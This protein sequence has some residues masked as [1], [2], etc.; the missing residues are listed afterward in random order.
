MSLDLPPPASTPNSQR[1]AG[2]LRWAMTSDPSPHLPVTILGLT[3]TPLHHPQPVLLLMSFGTMS[4]FPTAPISHLI[5]AR[6]DIEPPPPPVRLHPL[7]ILGLGPYKTESSH[8]SLYEQSRNPSPAPQLPISTLQG[9]ATGRMSRSSIHPH[10]SLHCPPRATTWERLANRLWEQ[11]QA[12]NQSYSRP[13]SHDMDI[14]QVRQ[15]AW[16]LSMSPIL[17]MPFPDT[18]P[19]NRIPDSPEPSPEPLLRE[20]PDPS[21]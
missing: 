1:E 7:H 16:T 17:P 9:T 11:P 15:T 12:S 4:T 3:G 21:N 19:I 2:D 10:R 5:A 13:L 20:T 14:G 18:T 6:L 8:L